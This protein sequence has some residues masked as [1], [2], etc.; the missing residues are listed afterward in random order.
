MFILAL[1]S[2]LSLST[3]VRC[4]K[5]VRIPSTA[6]CDRTNTVPLRYEREGKKYFGFSVD[7]RGCHH[8]QKKTHF[9]L[10]NMIMCFRKI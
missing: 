10:K 4:P 7:E 6:A 5:G 8:G 9:R 2:Q 3:K 1:L